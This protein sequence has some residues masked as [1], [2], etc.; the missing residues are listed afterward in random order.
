MSIQPRRALGWP[1]ITTSSDTRRKTLSPIRCLWIT[2]RPR[3]FFLRSVTCIPCKGLL[4][5]SRARRCGAVTSCHRKALRGAAVA[6]EKT[7]EVL[8][9]EEMHVDARKVALAHERFLSCAAFRFSRFCSTTRCMPVSCTERPPLSFVNVAC[10]LKA[11]YPAS[12]AHISR[13]RSR[14]ASYSP[15]RRVDRFPF[16]RRLPGCVEHGFPARLVDGGLF[17]ADE[18][19]FLLHLVQIH[20]RHA[21]RITARVSRNVG[22]AFPFAVAAE[23]AGTR[24]GCDGTALLRGMIPGLLVLRANALSTSSGT[25]R[26]PCSR[27]ARR[28]AS[29]RHITVKSRASRPGW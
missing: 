9:R 2:L 27:R 29:R 17:D 15:R 6:V 26:S 1:S 19:V 21:E 13:A 11:S 25:V 16:F 3:R 24:C 10:M 8:Q 4:S 5:R 23:E 28:S 7:P 22:A 14:S 20:A 18:P 12:V